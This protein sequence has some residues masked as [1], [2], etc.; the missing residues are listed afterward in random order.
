[1]FLQEKVIEINRKL[2]ALEGASHVAVWGAGLHTCKLFEK[3]E[4]LSY[5][6]KAVIDMDGRKRGSRYFGFAVK[7]PE[8]MEW[9]GAD[10]AVISVPGKE[11]EIAGMLAELGFAGTVIG[12]YEGSSCTPFYRLYDKDLPAIRY[13]GDYRDWDS[14]LKECRGYDD[15]AIL[16]K[17]IR[18]AKKVIAGEAAWERDGCLF[19]GRKYAYGICAAILRCAVQN[20]NKG[21]RILD[22]GGALGSTYFQNKGY[23]SDVRNLEYIVAEQDG[24][25][26]YGKKNMEGGALK[27]MRSG[28]GFADLGKVDIALMS[29]SLQY[30]PQHERIISEISDLK[31]RYIILD[32][33]LVSGRRRICV[34]TV[35]KAICESSYPA[36]IF[37]EGEIAGFFS[38]GGYELVEEDVSSVPEEAFF[39]DGKAESRLYVF[40]RAEWNRRFEG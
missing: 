27:F 16:D 25:A 9:D 11:R 37:S 26:E 18:S 36:T 10:A 13:M 29:A 34:E 35:P 15:G 30:I 22:V 3:T 4:L 1:M 6:I 19:Y 31:P 14:A 23:L 21:V 33:L 2:K 17:A 20:D 40:Q 5:P 39:S 32:R 24:H 12:L 38:G 28:E 7:S 8:E